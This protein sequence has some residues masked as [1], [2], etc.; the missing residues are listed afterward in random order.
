MLPEYL[1]DNITEY[2]DFVTR[3]EPEALDNVDKDILITFVLTFLSPD[4]VSNP[5]LK[6]KLVSILVHGL[7]PVGYYRKGTLYDRLSTH[8]LSTEYL[9]P[10]LIRFFIDVEST[11]GSSQFYG[12]F[13]CFFADRQIQFPPRHFAHLQ[14]VMVESSTSRGIR[15]VK[16]VSPS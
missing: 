6:G 5:F 4:Y 13:R 8:S 16:T 15:K 10:M 7:Q 9:M 1:F 14:I 2:L 12:K 3:Y 11:G